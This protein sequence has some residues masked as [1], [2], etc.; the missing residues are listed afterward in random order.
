M[1]S[2][3]DDYEEDEYNLLCYRVRFEDGTVI[4]KFELTDEE[5]EEI[6]KENKIKYIT[7]DYMFNGQFMKYITYEKDITFPF[8]SFKVEPPVFPYYP[9]T[10][11]LNGVDVT[12][13]VI[14]YLGPLQNFYN[15]RHDPVK[16]EDALLDHPEYNTF[17]LKEGR[18]TMISNETPLNGRKCITKDLPCVLTWKRHAAVD[19]REDSKLN[20]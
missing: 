14:P 17:N 11:I 7:I 6:D 12:N 13:Y 4:N 9:E 19:P 5:I 8:Y 15:D 16:L 3:E 20:N 10:V 1:K 18:L 2:F